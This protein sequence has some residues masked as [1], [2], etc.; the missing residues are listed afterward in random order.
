MGK[1]GSYPYTQTGQR[2]LGTEG[3]LCAQFQTFNLSLANPKADQV[4][5][6]QRDVHLHTVQYLRL[7]FEP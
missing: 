5:K 3:P 6:Q 7:R 4:F 1:E 2:F